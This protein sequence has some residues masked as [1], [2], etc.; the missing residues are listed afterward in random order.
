MASTVSLRAHTTF[1]RSVSPSSWPIEVCARYACPCMKQVAG[2][3]N[4][5]GTRITV[6]ALARLQ[7]RRSGVTA[8]EQ[9]STRAVSMTSSICQ[10]DSDADAYVHR[11]KRVARDRCDRRHIG[12]KAIDALNAGGWK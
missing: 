5:A 8:I 11:R 6:V 10:F 12:L 1:T 2:L 7:S 4:S 9:I 3:P